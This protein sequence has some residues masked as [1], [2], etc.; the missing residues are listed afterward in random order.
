LAGVYL[1]WQG[2][3]LLLVEA[4]RADSLVL[5]GGIRAAQLL[6]LALLLLALRGIIRQYRAP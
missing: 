5:P 2:L 6:G 3:T 1:G 4:L